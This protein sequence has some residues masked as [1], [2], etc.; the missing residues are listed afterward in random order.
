MDEIDEFC[1]RPGEWGIDF[2]GRWILA[3]PTMQLS[4]EVGEDGGR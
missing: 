4:F 1:E 3:A 2:A